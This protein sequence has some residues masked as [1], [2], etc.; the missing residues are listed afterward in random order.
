M[1]SLNPSMYR[2]PLSAENAMN[3]RTCIH[4]A[5]ATCRLPVMSVWGLHFVM[6]AISDKVVELNFIGASWLS[7]NQIKHVACQVCWSGDW[8]SHDPGAYL[9]GAYMR[10]L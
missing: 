1:S 7:G 6:S 9:E 5:F 3:L 2:R 8:L 10:R 4:T